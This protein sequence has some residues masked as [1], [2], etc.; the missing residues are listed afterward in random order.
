M[1]RIQAESYLK[2][3]KYKAAENMYKQI[4]QSASKH[5]DHHSSSPAPAPSGKQFICK[6]SMTRPLLCVCVYVCV[7]ECTCVSVHVCVS[8]RVCVSVCVCVHVC[9]C[10][11]VC[12]CVC[13]RVKFV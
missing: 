9:E 7:C 3:R 12:A 10:V 13:M 8:V 2:Q 6:P 1:A 4:L 5:Q 11:C